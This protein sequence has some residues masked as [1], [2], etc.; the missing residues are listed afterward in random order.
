MSE[1]KPPP[2]W[3]F[4]VNVE[5]TWDQVWY[6]LSSA[7]EGGIGYW[8]AIKELREPPELIWRHADEPCVYKHLDYP[9]NPGGSV[10]LVDHENYD[11]EY[12][13]DLPAIERGLQVMHRDWYHHFADFMQGNGDATTGD[14][15]VQCALF[16]DIIYG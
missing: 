7:M 1:P 13:L 12:V 9:M 16:G 6:L 10:V 11:K 15:L 5:V 14:V 8:A 2:K 3:T 4:K